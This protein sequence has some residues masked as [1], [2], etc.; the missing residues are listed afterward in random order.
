[1]RHIILFWMCFN[2]RCIIVYANELVRSLHF[3][4]SYL[5]FNFSSNF[6]SLPLCLIE[7]WCNVDT[8]YMWCE[9]VFYL[10]VHVNIH[11]CQYIAI[12]YMMQTYRYLELNNHYVMTTS[13]TF[14]NTIAFIVF[15]V[16]NE[17][18]VRNASHLFL[19]LYYW[20]RS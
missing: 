5:K 19:F 14:S 6:E 18:N 1:M 17:S 9:L 2:A 3:H 8:S 7:L 15:N 16:T 10:V 13:Y 11:T 12:L 20:V 4:C